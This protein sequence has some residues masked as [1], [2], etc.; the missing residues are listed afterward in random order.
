M[1]RDDMRVAPLA[2]LYQHRNHYDHHR[3]KLDSIRGHRPYH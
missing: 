3:R 1:R 2:V